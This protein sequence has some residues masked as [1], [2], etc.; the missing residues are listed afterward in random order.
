MKPLN[1]VNEIDAYDVWE[2]SL[3]GP[4]LHSEERQFILVAVDYASQWVEIIALSD[5]EFFRIERFILKH[6]IRRFGTP[7]MVISD[8]SLEYCSAELN[9]F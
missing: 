6:I 3:M 8:D 2:V 4:L 1:W 7:M 5:R 9:T